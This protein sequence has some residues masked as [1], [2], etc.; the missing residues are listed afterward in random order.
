MSGR[1]AVGPQVRD[2]PRHDDDRRRSVTVAAS[3][4]GVGG[5]HRKSVLAR[6]AWPAGC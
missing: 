6:K 1:E 2:T 3:V 4:V 5:L